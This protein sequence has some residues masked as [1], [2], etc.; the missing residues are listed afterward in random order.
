[1]N[2]QLMITPAQAA[3]AAAAW[4][5]VEQ[6]LTPG[7]VAKMFRVHPKTVTRWAKAG[8]IARVRTPGGHGRYRESDVRAL[9]QQK[10]KASEV[11]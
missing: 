5:A 6:L 7:E 10:A 4:S 3:A 1:M 8:R 2:P 9:L 11:K